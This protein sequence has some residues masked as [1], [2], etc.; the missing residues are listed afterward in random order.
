[1]HLFSDQALQQLNSEV[2]FF[3]FGDFLQEFRIKQREVLFLVGEK[4]DNAVTFDT[5]FQQFIDLSV[6]LRE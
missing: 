4:V 2:L 6:D 3:H 5:L 1:M